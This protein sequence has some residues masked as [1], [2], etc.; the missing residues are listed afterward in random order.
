MFGRTPSRKNPV[1]RRSA[2]RVE[3]LDANDLQFADEMPAGMEVELPGRGTAFVRIADGPRCAPTVLLVHGLFA[4]ADLNW[5]LAVPVLATRFC[6]VAPDLRGHGRG[7]PTRRFDG[8]ECADD[9]AAIVRALEL[10]PVIVV[11]YSLGGLIAQLFA[12]RHPDLIRGMVLCATASVFQVPTGRGM[13]RAVDWAARRAP[14]PLRRAALMAVLAPSSAE[15]PRGRWMMDQVRGHD[16][17]AMLDAIAEAGRFNSSEW[18]GA[19]TVPAAVIVTAEDR[20][21]PAETQRAMSRTL[22]ASIQEMEADHFACIKHPREFNAA[23]FAACVG[24]SSRA[25]DEVQA[26]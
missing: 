17:M 1:L 10:G 15:T 4:T 9:L 11:G 16:T 19:N 7:L 21:V 8:E 22:G 3:R 14:E 23:L 20:T 26:P 12:R 18:L 5:S 24:V 6:V 25:G 13:L 2:T